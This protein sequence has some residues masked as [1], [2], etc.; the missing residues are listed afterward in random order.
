MKLPSVGGW[1]HFH[2]TRRMSRKNHVRGSVAGFSEQL[3]VVLIS[4]EWVLDAFSVINSSIVAMHFKQNF[5]IGGWYHFQSILPHHKMHVTLEPC[6]WDNTGLSEQRVIVSPSWRM[7]PRT[8]SQSLTRPSWRCTS[9]R[10][11]PAVDGI[12][13]NQTFHTIRRMSRKNHV[14][15]RLSWSYEATGDSSKAQES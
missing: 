11:L 9:S 13:S 7:G 10:T 14:R 12:N 2:S 15:G 8:C 5:A 3:V 4:Y 1:Y 6:S